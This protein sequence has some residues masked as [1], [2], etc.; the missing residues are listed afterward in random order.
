VRSAQIVAAVELGRRTLVRAPPDRLQLL[1]A[2]QIAAYLLPAY[3]SRPVEQSGLIL[4]DTKH[5][6]LR[7]KVLSVGSIDT[8]VM[9]PREVF[10]EAAV[11]G[12]AAVVVFHN[13]P[14]GDPRPSRDD[15]LLTERLAVAGHVLGIRLLDHMI[16]AD[17]TYYSFRDAGLLERF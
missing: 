17:A 6:L 13:H 8:S 9:H 7:T 12:A 16:L 1:N 4:L 2:S 5:R 10:R 3:G 14:S 15:A 11:G